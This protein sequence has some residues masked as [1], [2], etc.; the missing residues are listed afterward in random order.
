MT[1]TRD[2]GTTKRRALTRRAFLKTTVGTAALLAAVQT[3]FPAGVHIAQAAG[4]EVTKANLGFIALTDAG[5]LFVAKDKGFFAKHGMPGVEVQKQA[6][7]GATRDNLVLGSEGNGIDGAHILT[8]M[9]YLISAGKVTQNNVPTPMYILARLNLDSQCI[10]VGKEYADLRIGLDTKPFKEA[11]DK[12]KASGKSVKAANTFPGGTHDLWIR[13]WLAAGGIDP[14]KDIETITVPPPQMVANMKVGTMDC[15]CVCEPWNLQLVHQGIGYTAIT[16]G[17]LWN[18]HPE[19]SL[20]MR[21]AWVDKNPNAAKA[22]TMAVM[23]AQQWC[24]KPENHEELATI[25]SKRQ[26]INAPVADILDR[27]K[28]KFDYGIPGKVVENSPHIMKYWRDFASYP[29]QSHDLWFI[30]EDIRWGKFEPDVDAKGLIGK[31]NREDIWRAAAKDLSV[32]AAQIPASTSRGKETFFDGKV[33][34]PENP[35]AYLKSLAIK[36][37]EIG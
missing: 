25:M 10:S 3:K 37:A 24:D 20:G 35:R 36:R 26:W 4:P 17:E 2:T 21:A 30:T 9:P 8:P 32:P 29:F 23:E 1:I 14:D 34:D 19:K 15:F 16:T 31:V 11:L 27:T 6:S 5:A 33:F 7:W 12:K 22:I 18:K 28:G 13:Y